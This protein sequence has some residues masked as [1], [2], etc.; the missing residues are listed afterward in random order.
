MDGRQQHIYAARTNLL[1]TKQVAS[2]HECRRDVHLEHT[3]HTGSWDSHLLHVWY[4]DPHLDDFWW[5]CWDSYSS[6]MVRIWDCVCQPSDIN[7]YFSALVKIEA[8]ENHAG[9]GVAT[10]LKHSR[11]GRKSLSLRIRCAQVPAVGTTERW[12]Q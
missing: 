12:W 2:S 7:R 11:A 4:I 1:S 6:T 8:L 9:C 3:V 5:K 10:F